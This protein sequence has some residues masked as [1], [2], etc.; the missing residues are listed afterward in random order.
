MEP[1]GKTLGTFL[2]ERL[3]NPLISSFIVAWSLYNYKIFVILFSKNTV[4][5]T[6]SLIHQRFPDLSAVALH[7]VLL[8]AV[9]AALYLFVLPFPTKWVY[10]WVRERQKAIDDIRDEYES[11]KRLTKEQS[12]EIRRSMRDQEAVLEELRTKSAQ[13]LDELKQSQRV[14]DDLHSKLE[15]ERRRR[16]SLDKELDNLK[17]MVLAYEEQ[18]SLLAGGAQS[19]VKSPGNQATQT[20]VD[21][22]GVRRK[23]L[24]A[25]GQ[26]DRI[27]KEQLRGKVAGD[28]LTID[29]ALQDL[30]DSQD[31]V[32]VSRPNGT[33]YYI[34][35]KGRGELIGYKKGRVN[36]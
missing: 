15:S 27:E 5:D 26:V 4:T 9:F 28:K 25:I 36:R 30:V 23:L 33:V 12:N 24:E 16:E 8:P 14:I 7:G 21:V 31:V 35:Q 20:N 17:L 18:N 10:K 19:G 3:S 13:L 34:S 32:E 6:F 29:Y 2:E 11:H 1:F 22:S